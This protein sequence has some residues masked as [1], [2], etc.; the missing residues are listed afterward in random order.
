[1]WVDE[2]NKTEKIVPVFNSEVLK[3][4][5]KEKLEEVEISKGKLKL[6]GLFVEI[7]GVSNTKLAK[8]IGIK[9]DKSYIKVDNERMLAFSGSGL[10]VH[11]KFRSSMLGLDLISKRETLSPD[12]LA[13]GCGLSQMA[14]PAHIMLDYCSFSMARYLWIFKK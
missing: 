5:G 9:L 13:L 10:F 7:G 1:M 8:L 14:L 2:V 6:S 11:E 4:I 3:L 12:G